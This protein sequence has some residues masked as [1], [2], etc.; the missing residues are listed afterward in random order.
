MFILFDDFMIIIEAML[1][2][3]NIKTKILGIAIVSATIMIP[4]VLIILAF[5]L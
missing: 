1:K 2:S 5:A 3:D 4:T